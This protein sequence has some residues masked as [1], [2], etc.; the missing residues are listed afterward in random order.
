MPAG[1]NRPRRKSTKMM[2]KKSNGCP[3]KKVSCK[4]RLTKAPTPNPSFSPKQSYQTCVNQIQTKTN[5]EIVQTTC[6]PEN[7]PSQTISGC[8]N[9]VNEEINP[10]PIDCGCIN[11]EKNETCQLNDILNPNLILLT[12]F[13]SAISKFDEQRQKQSNYCDNAASSYVMAKLSEK[14][15]SNYFFDNPS[16]KPAQSKKASACAELLDTLDDD[17]EIWILQTPKC[18]DINEIVNTNLNSRKSTSGKALDVCSEKFKS[19]V[20]MICLTPEKATE[21]KSVC[22]QIRLIQPKGK[23]M[24]IEQE[25]Q[26]D[27]TCSENNQTDDECSQ[28]SAIDS[29]VAPSTSKKV[30]KKLN[31][32]RFTIE[33]T[34]T[35]ENVGDEQSKCKKPRKSIKHESPKENLCMPLV[36]PEVTPMKRKSKKC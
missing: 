19:P 22:D 15:M 30:K 21:Y 13:F 31:D 33:T 14:N 28:V 20:N 17:T 16:I 29:C 34:V 26:S 1:T 10:H 3:L 25:V 32:Q 4:K 36:P 2:G 8:S 12:I 23:I 35:V 18:F 24:V 11:C 7:I 5:Q 6:I 27:M 9:A